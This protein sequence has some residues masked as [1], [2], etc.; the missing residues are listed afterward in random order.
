MSVEMSIHQCSKL[1]LLFLKQS[2]FMGSNGHQENKNRIT[3]PW[4]LEDIGRKLQNTIA[5]AK[6][7]PVI[8]KKVH[9]ISPTNKNMA[10]G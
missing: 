2:L 4:V 5:Y 7:L 3:Y 10:T 6:K 8:L 9:S 1:L